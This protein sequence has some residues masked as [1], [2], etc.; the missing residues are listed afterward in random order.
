MVPPTPLLPPF[1]PFSMLTLYTMLR[2]S[3]SVSVYSFAVVFVC[4]LSPVAHACLSDCVAVRLY[5]CVAIWLFGPVVA[6]TILPNP[7]SS[8]RRTSH[9]RV[10]GLK[11]L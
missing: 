7:A 9:R 4:R 8:C 2:Q 1:F 3:F 11:T 6:C 5:G 10:S